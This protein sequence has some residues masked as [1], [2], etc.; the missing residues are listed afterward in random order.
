MRASARVRNLTEE[1]L[2]AV[3]SDRVVA[4]YF[5][6]YTFGRQFL[7]EGPLQTITDEGARRGAI[8]VTVVLDRTRYAGSGIG[9]EVVR[10]PRD[11]LWHA[12]AVVLM[13]R[14]P[15]GRE[16][17]TILLVGSGNLT[18]A[19]WERNQEV[20]SVET[21]DG[22][23]LPAALR[24]WLRQPWL[25]R[26]LFAR[27]CVDQEVGQRNGKEGVRLVSSLDEPIWPQLQLPRTGSRWSE[28][29]VLAPF[30]DQS[31]DREAEPGGGGTA[32]FTVL[33]QHRRGPEAV[34]HVY[35][36]GLAGSPDTAVG[37]RN[38]FDRIRQT[39]K[40]RF[41]IV[42]EPQDRVLHAKLFAWKNRETWSVV[43]GSPN[44]TGAAMVRPGENIELA[45]ECVGIGSKLPAGLLPP[46][47]LRRF[48]DLRFVP[49]VFEAPR[50][51]TAVD[52]AMYNPKKDR[53]R[54]FWLDDH[55][56]HDTLILLDDKRRDPAAISLAGARDRALQ[57]RPRRR[58]DASCHPSWVPIEMPAERFDDL[59]HGTDKELT[60]DE[61]LARL[62]SPCWSHTEGGNQRILRLK[63]QRARRPGESDDGFA[64]S[65]RVRSLERGL[66]ALRQEIEEA[67][68]D[69]AVDRVARKLH[70]VWK[71]HDPAA[72]HLDGPETAWRRWVRAGVWRALCGCDG[73]LRRL[74]P[75]CRLRRAWAT[76]VHPKLKEFP[77]G[78]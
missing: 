3:A 34:L 74:R 16:T 48:E 50:T 65:D 58:S 72:P 12:K 19:G 57:V 46:S 71:S 67:D 4:A 53:V 52:Q 1:M 42:E 29:H 2:A 59:A 76:R 9:Y 43:T 41:H 8:P 32:F 22:W 77:I 27:W 21:W 63:E 73:R 13:T 26:S 49:P 44:A 54:L 38:V 30:T 36:R 45:W 61:W 40:V 31:G 5:S 15:G 75:L 35:L 17:R 7:E 14:R 25:S 47:T 56:P 60:P 66:K 64:W 51:W 20:F 28:A 37:S 55:G 6:T 18:R 39:A 62:G 24:T 33:F 70:G 68:S 11:R 78:S 23:S 69:M 10:A